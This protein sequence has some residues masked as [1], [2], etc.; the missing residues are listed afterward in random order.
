LELT[1]KFGASQRIAL[2]TTDEVLA[3]YL[4]FFAKAHEQIRRNALANAQ[5]VLEN[6]GVRV[7]PQSRGSFLRPA[8]RAGRLP[9]FVPGFPLTTHVA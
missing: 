4:T 9:R 3:E 8:F 7:V 6:P 2:V 5:R 1:S